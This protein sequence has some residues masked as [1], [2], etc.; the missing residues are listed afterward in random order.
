[1]TVLMFFVCITAGNS[2]FSFL[3]LSFFLVFFP[4]SVGRYL[5]DLSERWL[6]GFTSL[7]LG[8]T[9]GYWRFFMFPTPLM[10]WL[11]VLCFL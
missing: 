4:F 2:L 10:F 8:H 5:S 7:L 9:F 1:M 3:F 6:F 11:L